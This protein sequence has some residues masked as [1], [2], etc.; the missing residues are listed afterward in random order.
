MDAKQYTDLLDHIDF[1]SKELDI[2]TKKAFDLEK[3]R[4]KYQAKCFRIE[5]ENA[6]LRIELSQYITDVKRQKELLQRKET[7][8]EDITSRGKPEKIKNIVKIN[9]KKFIPNLIARGGV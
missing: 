9:F 2:E 1:L 7:Q 8:I 6:D 5:K 4:N 3:E